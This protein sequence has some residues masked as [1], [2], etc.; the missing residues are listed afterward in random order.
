MQAAVI[1]TSRHAGIDAVRGIA[2]VLMALDHVRDFVHADAMA[3][4]PDDLSRTSPVLFMTRWVTYFCAPAFLFIAGLSAQRRLAATGSARGVA[5][6]LATRGLWLVLLELTVFRFILDFRL[7]GT[8]PLLV[9]VLT[10]LGLSMLALAPFVAALSAR[11]IGV[12]GLAIVLLH[13]L[14][15]PIQAA[16]WGPLAPLWLFLHQPGAFEVAGHAVAVGYPVLP[17]FGVL[18]LGF[19]AGTLY[20][21]T[22]AQRQRAFAIAGALSLAAFI[23]LRAANVYGDPAPWSPQATQLFTALSFLGT[24]KYPPSLLFLLMTLGPALLALAWFERHPPSIRHPLAVIGRVP[25]FYYLAHFLLAHLLASFLAFARYGDFGMAFLSGPFPSLGGAPE[26]Y[27]RDFGWP[28]GVVY[29]AWA[30]VVLAMYPACVWFDRFKRRHK[31]AWW[32]G[33]V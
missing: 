3:F 33:Y 6:F 4:A 10:A 29:L 32:T 19:A 30:G 23:A 8:D 12:I 22:P 5:M 16:Q 26:T 1:P 20:E 15:D 7:F 18:A 14:L 9:L 27:P 28:L 13:N 2:M 11:A 21:A 31:G 24:T 17:W 25:L